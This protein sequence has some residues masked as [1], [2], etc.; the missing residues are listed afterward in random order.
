MTSNVSDL[1]PSLLWKY[2]EEILK[3]PHCSGNE[4]ALG[5]Y[6]VSVAKQLNLEH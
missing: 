2:F 6:I 3:I 5:G 4:K 1:Q